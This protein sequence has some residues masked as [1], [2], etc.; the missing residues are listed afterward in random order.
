MSQVKQKVVV[1]LGKTGLSCARFLLQQGFAVA[2]T[3]SRTQPPGLADLLAEYDDLVVSVGAFDEALM[4]SADELIVSPGV[5][6]KEPA[7]NTAI[8]AGVPAIGD[9]ELFCR[10]IWGGNGSAEN[11]TSTNNSEPAP[12]LIAITGSNAKS[13]VTTLV[14]DMVRQA[15]FSVIVAG[16]I[17]L[18]VMDVLLQGKCADFYVLE[19]SSFQ[20]ETTFHLNASVAT[21]LNISPDH[22]DRYDGMAGYIA[23]K[24]RIYQ[25][26][27]VA[28]VNAEDRRTFPATLDESVSMLLAF[29]EK[30]ESA[31]G[32]ECS[33]RLIYQLRNVNGSDSI[34]RDELP[35]IDVDN[36]ALSGGHNVQ[37]ALAALTIGHAAGLNDQPMAKALEKFGGLAHRCQVVGVVDGVTWINDSKGTN[38]GATIAALDGLGP[39]YKEGLVLI[40]G[41]EGKGADFEELTSSVSRFVDAAVLIGADAG[42]IDAALTGACDIYRADSLGMAVDQSRR[43]AKSGSAVLLSPA[44]A[45]F[46]MFSGFED[47]GDQFIA[48]V[49]QLQNARCSQGG[50]NER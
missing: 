17:G 32:V 27:H 22:L 48:A 43:L 18:P 28:V 1:G 2:V 13:T 34:Y 25:H 45:S 50:L 21:I 8:E 11:N 44:C 35:I 10:Y 15:G 24:Q 37:N 16:N 3:D 39:V 14:G 29:S 40:A 42:K 47:R 49:H 41:G 31:L 12:K 26:C 5:S 46:D 4:L 30:N 23:A 20:L 6:L 19:L 38:T 36:M 9:I 33:E 7:V